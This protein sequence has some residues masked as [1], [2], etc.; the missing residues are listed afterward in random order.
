MHRHA[1][2]AASGVVGG[3]GAVRMRVARRHALGLKRHFVLAAFVGTGTYAL[4]AHRAQDRRTCRAIDGCAEFRIGQASCDGSVAALDQADFARDLRLTVSILASAAT[5]HAARYH[6]VSVD[7]AAL[8]RLGFALAEFA[9]VGTAGEPEITGELA[10]L[11]FAATSVGRIRLG[12][13]SR[14]IGTRGVSSRVGTGGV[15]TRVA[16]RIISTTESQC[17]DH[18]RRAT[19]VHLVVATYSLAR[20][21]NKFPGRSSWVQSFRAIV[22]VASV[23]GTHRFRHE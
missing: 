8:I 1:R 7:G 9:T 13:G 21:F 15:T 23:F 12:I 14:G 18:H 4:R 6:A 5:G 10:R 20:A 22:I 11:R 17:Q 2:A 16:A 19:H 3:Y